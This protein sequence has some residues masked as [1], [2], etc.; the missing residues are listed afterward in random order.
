MHLKDKLKTYS[1]NIEHPLSARYIHHACDCF[2][3]NSLFEMII[4]CIPKC[5]LF[6]ILA[7]FPTV[8]YYIRQECLFDNI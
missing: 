7:L 4:A 6:C 2:F 5:D 3:F 1:I 8:P